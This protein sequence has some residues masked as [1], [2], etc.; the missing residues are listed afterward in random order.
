M[1]Y[2]N[3]LFIYLRYNYTIKFDTFCSYLLFYSSLNVVK[4]V[5]LPSSHAVLGMYTT[6]PYFWKTNTPLSI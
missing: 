6:F 5:Q 2:C 3:Q 1:Y 4:F